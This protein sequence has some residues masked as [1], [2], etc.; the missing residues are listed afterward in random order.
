MTDNDTAA[1]F[2][3]SEAFSAS[4]PAPV[5]NQVLWTDETKIELFGCD[6]GFILGSE[7]T[8]HSKKRPG[9]PQSHLEV[10]LS[11]GS[12]QHQQIL[13]NNVEESVTELKFQHFSD[14]NEMKHPMI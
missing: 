6:E 12:A 13:G 9:C 8:Q 2:N 7:R 4:S 5:W 1:S 14:Q 10:G 11:H 3:N